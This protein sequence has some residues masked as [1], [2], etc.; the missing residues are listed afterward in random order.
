MK[1][2]LNWCARYTNVA[3][4]DMDTFISQLTQAIIK[5]PTLM[6]FFFIN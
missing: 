5:N 2:S 4:L 3:H 6:W 1:I